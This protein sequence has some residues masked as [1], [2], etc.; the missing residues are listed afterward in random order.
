MDMK[1]PTSVSTSLQ[2]HARAATDN[3]VASEKDK[4]CRSGASQQGSIIRPALAQSL[5]KGI[6]PAFYVVKLVGEG[7]K[8][9]K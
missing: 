5:S 7:H 9:K 1:K 6:D 3:K 8:G 2:S 4:K